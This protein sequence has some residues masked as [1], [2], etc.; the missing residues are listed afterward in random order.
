M[1]VF[2][3][4]LPLTLA[5]A[6]LLAFPYFVSNG[7][8]SITDTVSRLQAFAAGD[9]EALDGF[10]LP[11]F[12]APSLESTDWSSKRYADKWTP[13]VGS[14]AA[15]KQGNIELATIL[16]ATELPMDAHLARL[17]RR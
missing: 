8:G 5:L 9:I 1:I 13:V 17:G 11:D 4:T 2:I 7:A 12:L 3:R 16:R 14:G 15:L 10:E 6:A